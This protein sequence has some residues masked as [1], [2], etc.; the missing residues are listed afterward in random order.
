M[1]ITKDNQVPAWLLDA[2][3]QTIAKETTRRMQE[4]TEEIQKEMERRTP[5]I[6]AGIVVEVMQMAE[7]RTMEDRVV[8]TIM[9][10]TV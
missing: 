7:F 6:I 8:F 9:K 2:I 5:E 4:A 3:E 10:K 1:A